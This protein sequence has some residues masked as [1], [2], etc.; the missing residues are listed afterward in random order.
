[1]VKTPELYRYSGHQDYLEAK[2]SAVLD[3]RRALALF[4]G[5]GSYKRFMAVGVEEGHKEQYYEVQD[6]RFLGA[7]GFGDEIQRT[8]GKPQGSVSPKP[9]ETLVKKLAHELEM[10]VEVRRS[11]DR[12]WAVSKARTVMAY[13]LVRRM[14]YRLGDVAAYLQRDIATAGTLVG[15]LYERMQADQQLLQQIERLA[16]IAE[17]E[18]SAPI[19][20]L[21]R[22]L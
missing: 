13:V 5:R 20:P 18:K 15:R 21:R 11:P 12:S 19:V 4:G 1:M 9:L 17:K 3:P 7:E 14:G 2:P 8:L 22:E 10:T 6:Q 16:K